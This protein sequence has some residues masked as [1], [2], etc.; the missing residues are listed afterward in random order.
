M[1]D[2]VPE[3]IRFVSGTEGPMSSEQTPF[4]TLLKRYRQASGLT[5]EALA[6]RAQLSARAISDLE[7]GIN[8]VPRYDTLELLIAALHVTTTQRALLLSTI[9]PEMTVAAPRSRSV[10]PPPLPPTALIGREQEMARALTFLQR[11]GVRLLT[12]TGPSGVGK[13]RLA[14]Q[15]AQDLGERFEQG[16]VFV[17]LAPLRDP[18]LLPTTLAQALGLREQPSGSLSELVSVSLQEQHL[19]LVLDNFEHIRQAAPFVA[20]LLASCP[21]L[22]VL[23][24]SRAPLHVRGEQELVVTPLALEAAVALFRARAQAVRPERD[25]RW[26]EVAPICEQVDRLPLAIELAAMHVKV[27][28]LPL[29]LKRLSSRLTLLS[30]GPQDLPERQRTLE[31]AIA[32]SYDLLTAA[33]QRC[34]RALGIFVGG[35]TLEAAEAVCRKAGVLARDE[36]LLA[37]A[38]LIDHSLVSSESSAG[39]TSRFSMLETLREYAL[40]RLREASEEEQTQRQHAIYYA[41]FAKTVASPRTGVRFQDAE[42][43]QDLPNLRAA[44]HWAARLRAVV[45]GLPLAA[46]AGHIFLVLGQNSEGSGWLVQMLELDIQAGAEAAPVLLRLDALYTAGRLARNLGQAA[47]AAA[48]AQEEWER[49]SR[50]GDHASMSLALANLGNLAQARDDLAEAADYFAQSYQHA[51]L[52][53]GSSARG[54]ALVNL[55]SIAIAQRDFSRAQVLLKE[56][57]E[58]VRAERFDWAMAN[59]LTMLGHV[60]REQRQYALARSR[61]RESLLLYRTFGNLSYTALCLEGMAALADAEGYSEQAVRLCAHA[62]ALRRKAQTPLPPREQQAFEQTVRTARAA[63]AEA[64]FN[65]AW[66]TGSAWTQE[67][68]MTC[69]LSSLSL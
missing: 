18:A 61:Y 51:Q 52:S 20:D 2:D 69:A 29:L 44:L 43:V 7:R 53:E 60:A 67:K 19:L 4:G 1:M 56:R 59:V 10:S 54:F 25:Y 6:A 41:E 48:L 35:W 55:A 58:Q 62:A 49:S 32:W 42:L 21:R 68:A 38:A 14:L 66:A 3:L 57:L 5:Q 12:L 23:V 37:L 17:A 30:A 22:Q 45:P 9:R 24:T 40:E 8:R 11:D 47:R 63:L 16:V 13:T 50:L 65:E 33:Q 28:A 39:G 26:T 27:L 31:S 34:F 46:C 15:L 36:V 64:T